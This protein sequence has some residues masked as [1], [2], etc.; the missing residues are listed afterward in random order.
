MTHDPNL[1]T[2]IAL[3]L[4]ENLKAEIPSVHEDLIETGLLDSLKIV[5]LLVALEQRFAIRI[6]LS[7]LEIDSFRSLE[8]I[9]NFVAKM[10]A[11]EMPNAAT[12]ASLNRAATP[13]LAD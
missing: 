5:E 3:L 7:E 10:K 6:P 4:M 9:T 11:K 1:Q 2:E 12:T 13:P 8:T